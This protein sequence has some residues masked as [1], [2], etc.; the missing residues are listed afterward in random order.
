MTSLVQIYDGIFQCQ[1]L[2]V[3]GSGPDLEIRLSNQEM[4][5]C[6]TKCIKAFALSLQPQL[7]QVREQSR[8]RPCLTEITSIPYLSGKYRKH[9]INVFWGIAD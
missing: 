4:H 7:R 1:A 6:R 9:I 5:L 3:E 2:R 8:L